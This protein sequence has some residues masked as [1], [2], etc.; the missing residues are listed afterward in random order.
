AQ[1]NLRRLEDVLAAAERE[2]D[3]LRR[4]ARQ[5]KRYVKVAAEVRAL[6]AALA[7]RRVADAR[8]REQDAARALAEANAAVEART[9][10]A[11]VAAARAAEAAAA[12]PPAREAEAKAS[13]AL[14]HVTNILDATAR[15][16]EQ[17]RLDTARA[18]ADKQ[19]TE[20]ERA[21]EA[22]L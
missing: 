12:L 13:A 10:E 14:A 17:I 1:E 16:L 22:A 20:E 21:R 3:Q 18:E 4:Q 15:E 11:A 9:R 19:H 8:A 6:Q 7:G 5:A 2:L